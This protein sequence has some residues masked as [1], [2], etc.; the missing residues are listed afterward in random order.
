METFPTVG[1]QLSDVIAE[2]QK[3]ALQ[4]CVEKNLQI[5]PYSAFVTREEYKYIHCGIKKKGMK[6]YYDNLLKEENSALR[7]PN[8]K[9]G[10]ASRSS[11][12]AC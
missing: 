4:D 9:T 8:F 5:N 2:R 6:M 1:F 10:M 7:F 12:L 3:P 11:W